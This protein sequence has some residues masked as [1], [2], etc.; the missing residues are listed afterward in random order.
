MFLVGKIKGV[1]NEV[2]VDRTLKKF[3]ENVIFRELCGIWLCRSSPLSY[4]QGTGGAPK[5]SIMLF[6]KDHTVG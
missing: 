2:F 4:T 1:D 6:V 3:T 5:R